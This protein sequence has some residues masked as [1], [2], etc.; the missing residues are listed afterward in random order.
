L[1]SVPVPP[2]VV[3]TTSRA[4]ATCATAVAPT[5]TAALPAVV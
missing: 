1:V 3:T 4:P 2:A 5:V